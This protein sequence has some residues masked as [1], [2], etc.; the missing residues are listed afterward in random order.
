MK[1]FILAAFAL[2]VV[3]GTGTV[4]DLYDVVSSRTQTAST[5]INDSNIINIPDDAIPDAIVPSDD[6]DGDGDGST[7]PP[8]P[9]GDE[10]IVFDDNG[11]DEGEEDSVTEVVV[12]SGDSG[13][14]NSSDGNGA[15]DGNNSGGDSSGDG[16]VVSASSILD[17][18]TGNQAINSSSG[19]SSSSGEGAG[20]TSVSGSK[21]REALLSRGITSLSVPGAPEAGTVNTQTRA[22][23]TRNDLAL[24]VSSLLVENPDVDDV[25]FTTDSIIITYKARGRLLFTIPIPYPSTLRLSFDEASVKKRVDIDFPWYKFLML[26]GVSKNTLRTTI[27]SIITDTPKGEEYDRATYIFTAVSEVISSSRGTVQGTLRA[28]Q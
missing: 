13:N 4:T 11:G 20:G 28:V 1:L 5:F 7:P 24:I 23:Y 9:G 27:D 21:T 2:L 22:P 14:G 10:V 16:E 8:V 26:T 6:D 18:L 3:L 12:N 19:A 17:S 15:S 25:F